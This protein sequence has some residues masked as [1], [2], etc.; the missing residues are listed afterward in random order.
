VESVY[1]VPVT[2]EELSSWYEEAPLGD[3][4]TLYPA[5]G[6]WELLGASQLRFTW[7]EPPVIPVPLKLTTVVGAVTE[8]LIIVRV[9]VTGPAVIGAN[10]TFS[11]VAW[12]ALREI[13]KAL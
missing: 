4:Y 6:S 7:Y 13:G 1:V 11:V 9:P 2:I 10:C 3:R 5:T 12:P 8:V